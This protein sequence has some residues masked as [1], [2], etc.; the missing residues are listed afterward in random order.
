MEAIAA[1]L[2]RENLRLVNGGPVLP[3]FYIA[4]AT[5][6]GAGNEPLFAEL[7]GVR[8]VVITPDNRLVLA[9]GDDML[10]S[11]WEIET[12]RRVTN[13]VGHAQPIFGM[14][15]SPDGNMLATV[16]FDGTAI[17]W[18]WKKALPPEFAARNDKL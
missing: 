10:I 14:A 17:L 18:D 16:G 5:C 8:S 3:T 13:L 7:G 9:A 4:L 6:R 11:I 12:G 15:L 1:R 2:R